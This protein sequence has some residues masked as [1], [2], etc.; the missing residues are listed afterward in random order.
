MVKSFYQFQEYLTSPSG[1]IVLEIFMLL[2]VFGFTAFVTL[3]W[4]FKDD[5]IQ[6]PVAAVLF[7]IIKFFS[8]TSLM[9]A[10][11]N[12]ILWENF[13]FLGMTFT[14]NMFYLSNVDV[15][16]GLLI[17]V[18]IYLFR[19]SELSRKHQGKELTVVLLFCQLR[20]Y[21]LL[22]D[23]YAADLLICCV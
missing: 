1:V 14:Y 15:S 21:Y 3:F 11:P 7:F 10:E 18:F 13:S 8:D 22:R 19:I 12:N 4:F 20:H 5:S 2:L 17:M 6:L 23:G 16:S 9:L